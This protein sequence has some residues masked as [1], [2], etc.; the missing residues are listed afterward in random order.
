M[1]NDSNL[2]TENARTN[3]WLFVSLLASLLF[4]PLLEGPAGRL[5][6]L[7]GLTSTLVFGRMVAQKHLKLVTMVLFAVALPVAWATLF[8]KWQWL[9]VVH[10]L[11]GSAFFWLV[12]GVIVFVVL[13]AH[14][15]TVDSIMAAISAYLLAGLAWALCYWALHTISPNAFKFPDGSVSTGN[16]EISRVV[17]FSQFIYYSFVT[18]TTLGYGDMSPIERIPRTL[19]WAQSVTGQFYVAV[20]V[21]W[22]VSALPRPGNDST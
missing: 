4:L 18:M 6:L 17:D 9:F 22:L 8:V 16:A 7:F 15:V 21:A 11:L 1:D 13:K 5:P 3:R 20:L 12:A 14:S 2:L 10:C 19:S